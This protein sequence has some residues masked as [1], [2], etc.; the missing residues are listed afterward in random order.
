MSNQVSL[1]QCFS[2]KNHPHSMSILHTLGADFQALFPASDHGRERA[3]WFL[4]TLQAIPA[5]ITA[6]HTS[7]LP[8]ARTARHVR[9][10]RSRALKAHPTPATLLPRANLDSQGGLDFLSG[11]TILSLS[12]VRLLHIPRRHINSGP[13]PFQKDSL[14]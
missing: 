8:R 13:H 1:S 5:P 3:R 9:Q 7:N 2:E 10:L 4:L 6:S 12:C 11:A 14:Q